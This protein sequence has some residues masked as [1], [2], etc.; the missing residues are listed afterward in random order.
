MTL[1]ESYVQKM[2]ELLGIEFEAFMNSFSDAPFQGLRVNGRKLSPE[3]Y[4]QLT[5]FKLTPVPW[6]GNGFYYEDDAAPARHPHYY[7]GLYYL[8]EPSAMTPANRL[9]IQPGHRVLDLCAA[10]GGKATE[11]G[12]R[13]QGSGM[14]LAN[15]ISTSRAKALLKNLELAGISNLC[16]SAEDPVH[17]A[18]CYPEY[19]DRILIDAPCSGEGMFRREHSMIEYWKEAGPDRYVPVQRSLLESG[20]S[21]LKKGGKLLYSTCTFSIKEDEENI[22]WIL[23]QHPELHLIPMEPYEGFSEGLLGLTDAV[24]IFPHRMKGEGHFLA[25]LQKEGDPDEGGN[26]EK[27]A[28]K[29]LPLEKLPEP[30]QEFLKLIHRSFR[31][32]GFL[33]ERE[34]V[35]YFAPGVERRKGIRYLRS[36]LLLGSWKKN[37]FEPSQALAM[38]LTMKEFVC[39]CSWRADDPRTVKYLKGE[40]VE[41][42]DT[43]KKETAWR[44]ICVDGYPLGWAKLAGSMLKNKYNPGWRW[45]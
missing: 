16:V 12:S 19:F 42:D 28:E 14:L 41:P 34:Q 15:D 45:Q 4:L 22:Q 36:G 8:Q 39:S 1:P 17:L 20:V 10:P 3:T 6:I 32:G 40:T 2:K 11:L 13:L 29:L 5:D 44:L 27:T 18:P 35:Y 21:M 25:L 38:T 26:A 24:R 23:E 33:I 31:E 43:E 7:A 30:V 37:R 9:D